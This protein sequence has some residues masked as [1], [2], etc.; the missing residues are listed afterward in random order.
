MSRVRMDLSA[1]LVLAGVLPDRP[2]QVPRVSPDEITRKM[3][4]DYLYSQRDLNQKALEGVQALFAHLLKTDFNLDEFMNDMINMIRRRLWIREVTVALLD[5]REGL[6]RYRYQAGLR[7]EAWEAHLELTYRREEYLNPGVY[8]AREISKQTTLFLAED[9][10]YGERED[11][12]FNR[13]IMLE[14]RRLSL[15]DTIEGDY[16]DSWI[17]G[18][19]RE[20]IGWVEYGG[21]TAGKFPDTV[22]LRWIEMAS[23]IAGVAVMLS[24]S[25]GARPRAAP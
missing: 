11:R 20:V 4:L 14:S 16:F 10:P 17:L 6:F 7:R 24:E 15:E 9:N 1:F 8:K 2:Q 13:P 3:R 5:R 18:R 21:T 25:R 19:D 23:T 22:T 12:T